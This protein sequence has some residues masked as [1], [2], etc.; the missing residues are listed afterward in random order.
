VGFKVANEIN[1]DDHKIFIDFIVSQH[2]FIVL[3]SS[4]GFSYWYGFR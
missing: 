2:G 1:N 3:F 4:W